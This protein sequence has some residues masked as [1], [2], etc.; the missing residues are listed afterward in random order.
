MS[1]GSSNS[2]VYVHLA[3]GVRLPATFS[4]SLCIQTGPGAHPASCAM[5]T[6]GKAR[7]DSGEDQWRAFVNAA[8]NIE[9]HTR[10][11]ISWLAVL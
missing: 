6:G 1:W 9:F 4:T 7:F 2:V 5:D 10:R 11:G 8:V 3:I